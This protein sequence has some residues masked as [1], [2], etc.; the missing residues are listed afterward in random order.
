[1]IARLC[2]GE[3]VARLLVGE[4]VDRL[5]VGERIA[6]W[7][8]KEL[9]VERAH[10]TNKYI[11]ESTNGLF[12]SCDRWEKLNHTGMGSGQW[13][14]NTGRFSQNAQTQQSHDLRTG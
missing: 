1:M 13:I 5:L 4:L 14:R 2:V 8:Q 10:A 3:Q 11:N 7:M 12:R 9:K 6:R